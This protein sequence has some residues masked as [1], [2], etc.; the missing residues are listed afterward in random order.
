MNPRADQ[1]EF[2]GMPTHIERM[3]FGTGIMFGTVSGSRIIDDHRVFDVRG[4]GG[5]S[6]PNC[7]AL[8]SA[9]EDGHAWIGVRVAIALT[10][11]GSVLILGPVGGSNTAL[12]NE[13]ADYGDEQE[14]PPEFGPQDRVLQHNGVRIVFGDSAQD[15]LLDVPGILRIQAAAVR[16]SKSGDSSEHL[17]KWSDFRA[18][19]TQVSDMLL[20][21]HNW[22]TSYESQATGN[23][24]APKPAPT[25]A[26]TD[27]PPSAPDGSYAAGAL[28]VPEE[29]L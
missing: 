12:K 26:G 16:F 28:T 20:K 29:G 7:D 15:L 25:Y 6:Y 21:V 17:V 19:A 8:L 24:S 9:P 4:E 2:P 22:L 14:R 5:E 18:W 1:P 3:S 13:Q 10:S 27:T 23:P 11:R